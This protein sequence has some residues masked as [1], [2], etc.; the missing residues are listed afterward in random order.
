MPIAVSLDPDPGIHPIGLPARTNEHVAV[1]SGLHAGRFEESSPIGVEPGND[2]EPW[3]VLNGTFPL[4]IGRFAEA[5]TSQTI[6]TTI[7]C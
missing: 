6:P 4:G 1:N 2:R 5:I 7:A 3:Q